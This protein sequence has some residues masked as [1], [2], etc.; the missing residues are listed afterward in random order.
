MMNL[1][2]I[3][4]ADTIDKVWFSQKS[5]REFLRR[6]GVK[7]DLREAIGCD[8]ITEADGG[9]RL[10]PVSDEAI[11][12]FDAH[13][14][15]KDEAVANGDDAALAD[16]VE[17]VIE[18]PAPAVPEA[19]AQAALPLPDDGQKTAIYSFALP[20]TAIGAYDVAK[21]L[22]KRTGVSVSY[23]PEGGQTVTIDA[24]A[25][26]GG[27]GGLRTGGRLTAPGA[28]DQIFIDLTT[29]DGGAT[30]KEIA[31]ATGWKN[32]APIQECQRIGARWGY[33]YRVD[34]SVR[35]CT[36]HLTK[37]DAAT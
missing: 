1:P 18:D 13:R 7:G 10:E 20:L 36:Y 9:V 8:L 5:A 6:R 37:Q 28:S 31:D 4:T 19:P 22:A 25:G 21:L 29:R 15:A 23:A 26:G 24:P 2:G 14:N 33:D 17:A 3:L 34:K 11:C 27:S 12:I 35:P 16:A 32:P 30:T